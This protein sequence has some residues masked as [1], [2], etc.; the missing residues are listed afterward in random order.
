MNVTFL[1]P[2]TS[3]TLALECPVCSARAE[4]RLAIVATESAK[5]WRLFRCGQCR[6]LFYQPFPKHEYRQAPSDA[7]RYALRHYLEQGASIDII[8][9][10]IMR[11]IEPRSAGKLLDVGCGFGFAMDFVRRTAN[12]EVKGVEPSLMGSEGGRQLGLPIRNEYLTQNESGELFD[13]VHASHVIE[14]IDHPHEFVGVLKS[15]LKPT[16]ILVLSCPNAEAVLPATERRMLLALI[17]PG[18]H[19]ILFTGR[20]LELVLRKAGFRFF[21]TESS[22]LFLTVYASREPF[23]LQ[24]LDHWQEQV[25]EY[26]E[27]S[28]R[29]VDITSSLGVGLLYRLYA[30]RV[31]AGDY[32]RADDLVPFINMPDN[33]DASDIST[34]LEFADR[35]PI[36]MPAL[37]YYRAM[38]LLNGESNFQAAADLFRKAS[39][40]CSKAIELRPRS[41]QVESDLMWRAKLCEALSYDYFGESEKASSI[42]EEIVESARKK[43]SIAEVPADVAARAKILKLSLHFPFKY[44][45][46]MN[47]LREAP[48]VRKIVSTL[49]GILMKSRS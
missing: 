4:K 12:W 48:L 36:C 45:R 41:A 47:M 17:S 34:P 11:A 39:A 24:S 44:W 8:G 30:N 3:A 21:E 38:H 7:T 27:G 25:A 42:L 28:I 29:D 40:L 46:K 19:A 43:T 10:N 37:A 32:R 33:L 5:E 16:G 31:N 14:H 26:L 9:K 18:S 49:R 35:F 1:D 23:T 13:V 2:A 22:G 20:S 15:Y 6:S